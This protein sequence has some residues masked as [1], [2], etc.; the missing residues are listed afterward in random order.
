MPPVDVAI[1]DVAEDTVTD[2]TAAEEADAE[3]ADAEEAAAE[4]AAV[5]DTATDPLLVAAAPLVM[6]EP[7]TV[8]NAG[9]V[10]STGRV[11]QRLGKGMSIRVVTTAGLAPQVL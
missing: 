3:E 7:V 11:T 9:S 4:E 10:V 6:T 5:V 8:G 2:E 1:E